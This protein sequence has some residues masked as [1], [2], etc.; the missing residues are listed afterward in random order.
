M[1]KSK[2]LICF[3]IAIIAFA[4]LFS[5][6]LRDFYP[7]RIT[8]GF[9]VGFVGNSRGEL[10]IQVEN[11][12]VS[13]PY[14]WFN[15]LAREYQVTYMA[16]KYTVK[17]QEWNHN[18]IYPMNIF[19][20]V[21]RDIDRIDDLI[22]DLLSNSNVLFAEQEGVAGVFD[23]EN[24]SNVTRQWFLHKIQAPE[25]WTLQTGSPDVVVGIV[26]TGV[27]WNHPNLYPNIWVNEAE[28]PGIILNKADGDIDG[29][30]GFDND[31]NGFIDDFMG[32]N[33]F[34]NDSRPQNNPFQSLQGNIQGT[35]LS[36]IVAAIDTTNTEIIG[37]AHTSKVLNT[38]H[39]AFGTNTG[40][41]QMTDPIGGIYYMVDTG[42][43]IINCSWRAVGLNTDIETVAE[44][45]QTHGALI[46]AAA[47]DIGEQSKIY[48]AAD[49]LVIAVAAT[50]SLDARLQGS[51]YGDWIDISAPG[52]DIMS[53]SFASNGFHSTGSLRGTAPAA[54]IVS[55]V[56]ALILSQ[57]PDMTVDQLR[58]IL[59]AGVD[60]VIDPN[61]L[62]MGSGRVNAY[63][64]V[65]S[66]TVDLIAQS[67]T[68]SSGTVGLEE[69]TYNVSVINEGNT[70]A[71]SYTIKLMSGL[72]E[73][74]SVTGPPIAP[75]AIEI[76]PITWTPPRFGSY[77]LYGHV[78][79][80][81]DQDHSNNTTNVLNVNVTSHIN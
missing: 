81:Y 75:K 50:D 24:H 78:E 49:P 70:T 68:G 69:L 17:N 53:T 65:Q 25:A 60:D 30:D 77:Q 26:D 6:D 11:G 73:L 74:A 58:N 13:T 38:K 35:H 48:P 28:R 36:G 44:Y 72:S 16:R 61:S 21:T 42:V 52:G 23:T 29:G 51:S 47:G 37:I 2:Y 4:C 76:I 10:D 19:R 40:T 31:G 8:V 27:S 43:R 71:S 55:G 41:G 9:S 67:L 33:F 63:K 15:D 57:N 3:I 1:K 5:E 45:A 80:L 34:L 20:L 18:G 46:I 7:D 32:W 79:F 14:I 59:L 66:V 56:A 39:I 12:I 62:L 64:G 22:D 54:A